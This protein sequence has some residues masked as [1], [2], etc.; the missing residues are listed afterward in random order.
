M[1]ACEVQVRHLLSD[2]YI[3]G[4]V[5]FH[6]SANDDSIAETTVESRPVFPILHE[7]NA[8][9]WRRCANLHV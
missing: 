7:E 5:Q 2:I 3:K 9:R 6:R 1:Y 4:D 8:C